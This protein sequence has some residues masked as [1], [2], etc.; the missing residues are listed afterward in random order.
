MEDKNWR[1]PLDEQLLGCCARARRIELD[2]LRVGDVCERVLY[3]AHRV[4][5][6]KRFDFSYRNIFVGGMGERKTDLDVETE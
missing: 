5:L 1:E 2:R 3:G 4:K 6:L